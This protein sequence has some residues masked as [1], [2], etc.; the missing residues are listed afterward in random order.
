MEPWI[1]SIRCS[2]TDE[3]IQPFPVQKGVATEVRLKMVHDAPV[4]RVVC[5]AVL[6][7][8]SY[9]FPTNQH[10][11]GKRKIFVASVPP[12]NERIWYF[13][14]QLETP[15]GWFFATR[16]GL[17]SFHP[18]IATM[19]GVDTELESDDWVP[20]S[21]FYQI[22]PDR[23]LGMNPDLGVRTG[24]YIFDGHHTRELSVD[25]VPP[26]YED[27]W[28]LDFYNGDLKGIAQS[29]DHLLD[30]GIT[31]VYLNPIFSAKTNHRYDCT[32]FFH[33]DEHLGGDLAL[34]HLSEQL[35]NAGI[36]IIVD[37]SINHSGIEHPWFKKAQKD[38]NSHEADF[39]YR[40]EAGNFIYWENVHTLP[41]LNYSS[42]RLRHIMYR[43]NDSVLRK[44]LRPPFSIDGWRFDVGTDTGRRGEDQFCHQIW[45]EV[46]SAIKEVN[47]QSYI[48]G[49]AWEDASV[50]IQG[51]Q[52]D[53]AMNYFGSG[54]LL[55]RWYGQQDTYLMS[56]WGHSD[57]T[58]RA[59]TGKELS[60]AIAQHLL[61]IPEQLIPRQFNL[62][63]SHDTMRLHNHKRIF[64]WNLY[65]GIVMLLFVL[66]GVP[67]VYYGDEIGLDGTIGSN[68]GARYP[69]QW[70]K[71]KWDQRFVDLYRRLGNLRKDSPLFA[72]GDWHTLWYDDTTVVFSRIYRS[73]GMIIM[74][75]R[76]DSEKDISIDLRHLYI[77]HMKE[78]K[79]K[80]TVPLH[81][82][83]FAWQVKERK[84]H[85]FLFDID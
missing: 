42:D 36:R 84:S 55:R 75:N 37:I 70:N 41:Q 7:G 34:A 67:S 47:K 21:T 2:V 28:C 40:D 74:L 5:H 23:F 76:S 12:S 72:Y 79:S 56:N 85:L 35:H 59:L 14:F 48:I 83:I 80:D 69:M 38:P 4:I 45:K 77:T 32:D 63:D 16:K 54:R 19:Y 62:I 65:E 53:S 31:A 10:V 8:K 6:D 15:Q 60:D 24:E 1:G 64:D 18:S 39:Y 58:G 13:S 30:M 66:P 61:S 20:G 3:F 49:E 71:R 25:E 44:F 33:V 11:V 27:G 9:H 50:Y 57:E 26:A 68:E 52:W 43:G 29:I 46:R 78:W 51:D 17:L 82:G 81:E 22:F 73:E